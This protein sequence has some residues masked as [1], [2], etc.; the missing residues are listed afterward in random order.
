MLA[1]A[2]ILTHYTRMP[3]NEEL[4]N[5]QFAECANWL[6]NRVDGERRQDLPDSDRSLLN[7]SI[8]KEAESSILIGCQ[9]EGCTTHW[10]LDKCNDGTLGR[11]LHIGLDLCPQG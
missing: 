10:L 7:S 2:L 4:L 1:E 3:F 11:V 9:A 8:V 6:L 5:E